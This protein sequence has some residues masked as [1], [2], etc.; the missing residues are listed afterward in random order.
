MNYLS[1]MVY[2]AHVKYMP[3][4][5]HTLHTTSM[6]TF[7]HGRVMSEACYIFVTASLKHVVLVLKEV[8]VGDGAGQVSWSA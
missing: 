3:V 2:Y 5:M 1:A 4:H 7:K 8:V 6:C